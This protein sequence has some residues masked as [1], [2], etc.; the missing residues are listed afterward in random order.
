MRIL[1]VD[2]N[3]IIR[4][5]L[6]ALLDG[7]PG[8]TSVTDTGDPDEAV[9]HVRSGAVDVVLLDVRMPR[10]SGLELLPQLAGATVVMLTHTDD[11]STVSEAIAAG[12]AGYLV[13]GALEPEAM[14]DAIRLCRSGS[15]VVAGVAPPAAVPAPGPGVRELLSPR[16]AEVMDLVAQGLS[17]G[18]VAARL[19]ISEKTVKNHVNSLFA[20]L[21]VTTRSQAIVRWLQQDARAGHQHGPGAGSAQVP[22]G[23]GPRP[24]PHALGSAAARP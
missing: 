2:D 12:A 3:P 15:H 10:V 6:R 21:G 4:M 14:V 16:E 5:G 19:F 20:K 23:T 22:G 13:H 18:E 8:V 9:A 11:P 7:T 24:G 1:A 17:N